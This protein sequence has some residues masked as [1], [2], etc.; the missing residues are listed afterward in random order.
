MSQALPSSGKS[1]FQQVSM[2]DMKRKYWNT[3]KESLMLNEEH[4]DNFK[5]VDY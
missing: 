5:A 3:A 4:S 2:D 1:S